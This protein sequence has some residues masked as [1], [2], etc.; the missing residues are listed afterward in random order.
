M[1]QVLL[2]LFFIA[3]G[4]F[5][6]TSGAQST[7]AKKD[8]TAQKSPLATPKDTV[9]TEKLQNRKREHKKNVTNAAADKK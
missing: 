9:K 7:K 8:T 5:V 3:F 2:I 4:W 1:K 6:F